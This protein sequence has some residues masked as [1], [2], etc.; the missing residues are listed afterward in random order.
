MFKLSEMLCV[1]QPT[2]GV[3]AVISSACNWEAAPP[4]GTDRVGKRPRGVLQWG[5]R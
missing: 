5:H 4:T 1:A 3:I 2:G